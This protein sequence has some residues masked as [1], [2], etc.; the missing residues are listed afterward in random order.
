[1][2]LGAATSAYA[3]PPTS[4]GCT[5]PLTATNPPGGRFCVATFESLAPATYEVSFDYMASRFAGAID[6]TL[7]FGFLFGTHGANIMHGKLSDSTATPGWNTYSF[8]A[9]AADDVTLVFGLRGNPGA[10]FG[11]SLQNVHITAIPAIPEPAS[12]AMLLAGLGAIVFV[13]RRRRL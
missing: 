5:D 3:I 4:G 7:T 13:S 9:N 8:L 1:V 2:S 11:M 10:N 6:Q 12:M